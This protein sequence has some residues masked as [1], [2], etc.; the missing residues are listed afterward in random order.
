MAL[1]SPDCILCR[2]SCPDDIKKGLHIRGCYICL[3]C[4]AK[5]ISL[6]VNDPD[7]KIYMKRLKKIWS[8]AV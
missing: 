6:S 7:Y 3:D 8:Q 2:H 1:E 5:I 4:E